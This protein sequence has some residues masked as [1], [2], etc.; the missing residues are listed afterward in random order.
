MYTKPMSPQPIGG[1]LDSGFALYR[2]TLMGTFV[3]AFLSAFAAIPMRRID[4]PVPGEPIDIPMLVLVSAVTLVLSMLLWT[5]IIAKI[6]AVQQGRRLSAGE[7]LAVGIRRLPVVIPVALLLGLMLG[8]G[9]ALLVIPGIYLTVLFLFA[10]VAAVAD[11]KGVLASFKY[12][13]ELVR[14]RWWRTAVMLTVIGV[15][16]LVA[17]LLVG[18]VIAVFIAI[19][20]NADPNA[21]PWQIELIVAPAVAG[22]LTPLFYALLMA[23]YADAKLR[24]EGADI[25]ERIAAS[26]A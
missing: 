25:A 4:P 17:Y 10:P 3:F 5:P 11:S 20:G 24:Y 2:H 8:I 12:S 23:V 7:A 1:V 18:A 22:V 14:R 26:E 15:V 13:F 19:G 6:H 21:V 16:A 9:F